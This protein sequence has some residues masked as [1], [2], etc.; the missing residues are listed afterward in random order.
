MDHQEPYIEMARV[1]LIIKNEIVQST[2]NQPTNIHRLM[3][4]FSN[5]LISFPPS[6]SSLSHS[7]LLNRLLQIKILQY[8]PTWHVYMEYSN[9]LELRVRT[10]LCVVQVNETLWWWNMTVVVR[11]GRRKWGENSLKTRHEKS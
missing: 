10:I 11:E 7:T 1:W 3:C 4:L 2:R 9:L 8:C 6:C 5:F